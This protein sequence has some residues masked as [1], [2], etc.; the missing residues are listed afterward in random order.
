MR[1]LRLPAVLALPLLIALLAPAAAAKPAGAFYTTTFKNH[2]YNAHVS[3]VGTGRR[4]SLAAVCGTSKNGEEFS[5]RSVSATLNSKG[6]A[7]LGDDRVVVRPGGV[8][9]TTA[10]TCERGV[11]RRAFSMK[12]VTPVA[13]TPGHYRGTESMP[14][15]GDGG[16]DVGALGGVF[17]IERSL[18]VGIVMG[19]D[20]NVGMLQQ[21]Q[22]ITANFD[23]GITMDGRAAG[24]IVQ[25]TTTGSA[26]LRFA[27]REKKV[28]GTFGAGGCNT[29]GGSGT[30]G[31]SFQVILKLV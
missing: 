10:A 31:G 4:V 2:A 6:R 9:W 22:R 11:K 1:S 28:S 26:S 17:G 7:K 20:Q 8:T 19:C 25:G 15:W 23:V 21:Q 30:G 5:T 27:K 24:R 3:K 29:P 18:N 13:V 14:P 16:V 12:S